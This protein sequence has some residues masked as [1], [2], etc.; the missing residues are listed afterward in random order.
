MV[1][2]DLQSGLTLNILE[3]PFNAFFQ[4]RADPDQAALLRA[5]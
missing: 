3:M 1:Y 2:K 4:N 5:A